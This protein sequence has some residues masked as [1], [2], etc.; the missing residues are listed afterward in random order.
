MTIARAEL[1]RQIHSAY[2]GD[3]YTL[4][5]AHRYA[6]TLELLNR[7]S[8]PDTPLLDIG[9]SRLTDILKTRFKRPIHTLGF[10]KEGPTPYGHHYFYNLNDCQFPDRYRTD[11]PQYGAIVMAEVIEHLYT[12]PLLVYPFLKSVLQKDG[13]FIVQTP[14]A[15]ALHKRVKMILGQNPYELIRTQHDNP[16]HFREYTAEELCRYGQQAGLTPIHVSFNNYF[17]YQYRPI[18][19]EHPPFPQKK[20]RYL[21]RFFSLM[22]TGLRPGLTVVYQNKKG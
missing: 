13:I 22:P 16:G 11:L 1:V 7:F 3:G 10:E 21:N 18:N 12:S 8:A 14:N 9:V 20:W 2:P 15:V 17:D 19:G 5:H 6:T 4:Y